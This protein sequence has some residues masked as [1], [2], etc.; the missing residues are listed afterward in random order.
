[1]KK[2]RNTN[3]IM[4]GRVLLAVLLLFCLTGCQT[5]NDSVFGKLLGQA[6][7]AKD[8]ADKNDSGKGSEEKAV[9]KG[10]AQKEDGEDD[11]GDGSQSGAAEPEGGMQN[12]E[13]TSPDMY[14]MPNYSN[15]WNGSVTLMNVDYDTLE[16]DKEANSGL[17]AAIEQYNREAAAQ[18]EEWKTVN[19]PYA[20][21]TYS[22]SGSSFYSFE[23]GQKIQIRRADERILSFDVEISEYT[24]GA[25]GDTYYHGKSFDVATGKEL[26]LEDV[27]TDKSRLPEVIVQELQKKYP[28]D[29]F[30]DGYEEQIVSSFQNESPEYAPTWTVD[31]CGL[32]FYYAHYE[33][34]PYSAGT[35]EVIVPFAQY[36][37]LFHTA[38]TEIP[39]EYALP[40]QE[41]QTQYVDLNGDG[42]LEE[43]YMYMYDS[44]DG[45]GYG[46]QLNIYVNGNETTHYTMEQSWFDTAYLMKLSDGTYYLYVNI[47]EIDDVSEILV[48]Y[49]GGRGAVYENSYGGS[50]GNR[51]FVT[52]GHFKLISH[53]DV[54][55]TYSGYKYYHVGNDGLPEP[56]D[57]AYTIIHYTYENEPERSLTAKIPVPVWI[58]QADGSTAAAPEQLPAGTRFYFRKTDGHSYVEMELEDGRHCQVRVDISSWPRTVNGVDENDCFDGIMY[59]G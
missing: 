42:A 32:V 37:D 38:Y 33:L 51:I 31:R 35:L 29:M 20:E 21:D 50:M 22:Y 24:G 5:G 43:I 36:P 6:E 18:A 27:V 40:M 1:M 49:L 30:F 56:D 4:A 13:W 15:E 46:S 58:I 7:S 41:S 39:E 54:L 3:G 17:T 53:L 16:I 12:T 14:I 55:S 48:F 59:A 8:K 11:T 26:T 47:D 23:Y 28:A 25:H 2:K 52:P 44:P 34:A 10:D 19:R 45:Y 9:G 57:K